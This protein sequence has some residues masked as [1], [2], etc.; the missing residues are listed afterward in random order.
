M[1]DN[2]LQFIRS[3]M[4]MVKDSYQKG[5]Y[6]KE[7]ALGHLS[8]LNNLARK[9]KLEKLM[10][11]IREVA[12][13]MNLCLHVTDDRGIPVKEKEKGKGSYLN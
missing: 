6:S 1:K 5:V 10:G 2:V 11:D 4:A 13:H 12:L 7:F 8:C 9:Y 3:E